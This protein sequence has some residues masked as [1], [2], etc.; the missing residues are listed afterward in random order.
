MLPG[1]SL[2]V[3]VPPPM[4]R[5]ASIAALNAAFR[6]HPVVTLVGPRQC[7]KTTL[8]LEYAKTRKGPVLHL[9]LELASDLARLENPMLSLGDARGLVIIDEVQRRPDLFP[10]LRV[11][12]DRAPRDL[13]ARSERAPSRVPGSSGRASP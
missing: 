10:A 1:P 7:G 6:V 13:R 3:P 11:I 4:K 2:R 12:V 9:D 5:P 8:A